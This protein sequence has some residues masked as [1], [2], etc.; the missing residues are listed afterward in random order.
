MDAKEH[1]EQIEAL[2]FT[3]E[4]RDAYTQGHSKRVAHYASVLASWLGM[5]NEFVKNIH[6]AG[7]LHDLGK[8][9]IPDEILLK[10]EKLNT[11]EYDL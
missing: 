6:T 1:T 8:I 4:T 2:V 5:D 7:M 10:P 11:I 3:I 9:G